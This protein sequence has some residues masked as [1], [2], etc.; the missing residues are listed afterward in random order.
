MRNIQ[1]PARASQVRSNGATAVQSA[2]AALTDLA[3]RITKGADVLQRLLSDKRMTGPW[4]RIEKR[5]NHAGK[6]RRAAYH[7]LW[8]ELVTILQR[9]KHPEKSR[10][11]ERAAWLAIAADAGALATSI[12]G[13]VLDSPAFE[14]YPDDVAELVFGPGWSS[15]DRWA[16][17]ST[18]D[19]AA[20]AWP[21]LPELL[22]VLARKA[23]SHAAAAVDP[24]KMPRLVERVSSSRQANYFIRGMAEYFRANLGGPM[25]GSLA[26]VASVVLENDIGIDQVK[27]A[28][29]TR[30]NRGTKHRSK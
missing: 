13:T 8:G 7:R 12:R 17:Q 22:D 18:A 23:S 21:T 28:L 11:A 5:I 1:T 3:R 9:S 20:I 25:M 16:R 24:G 29:A 6:S 30:K 2:P 19:R 4:R 27:R 15:L 14:Y 26:A 10:A